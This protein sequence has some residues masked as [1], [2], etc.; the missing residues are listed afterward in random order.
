MKIGMNKMFT[1]P[2][3]RRNSSRHPNVIP[4]EQTFITPVR[5]KAANL[6][7]LPSIFRIA[8]I[9]EN[10]RYTFMG[11]PGQEHSRRNFVPID[12]NIITEKNC[13]RFL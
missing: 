11:S 7:K 8:I 13:K 2:H 4:H 10:G 1:L 3:V 6:P 5:S 9:I 12:Q